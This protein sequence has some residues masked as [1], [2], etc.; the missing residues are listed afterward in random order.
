MVYLVLSIFTVIDGLK[1]SYQ[2]LI[3]MNEIHTV[4]TDIHV[5]QVIVVERV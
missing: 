5:L 2:L 1:N 3:G 4:V